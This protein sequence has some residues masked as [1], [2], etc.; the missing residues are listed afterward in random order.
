MVATGPVPVGLSPFRFAQSVFMADLSRTSVCPF[1]QKRQQI[2]GSALGMAFEDDNGFPYMFTADVGPEVSG[3]TFF[4]V[5]GIRMVV[6]LVWMTSR[7]NIR[8]RNYPVSGVSAALAAGATVL[9]ANI[10]INHEVDRDI[11]QLFT[12]FIADMA[13]FYRA[14]GVKVVF[15]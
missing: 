14:F 2:F 9:W 4:R 5:S 15:S 8:R 11:F 12:H 13:Q 3:C 6:S 1:W 10:L 7:V